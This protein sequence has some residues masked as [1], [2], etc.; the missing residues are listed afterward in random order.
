M[1]YMPK[2]FEAP[3]KVKIRILKNYRQNITLPIESQTGQK[4]TRSKEKSK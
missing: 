2:T 3:G 4:K 1:V